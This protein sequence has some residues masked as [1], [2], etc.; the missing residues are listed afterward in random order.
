MLNGTSLFDFRA[1]RAFVKMDKDSSG[2]IDKKELT[3][4]MKESLQG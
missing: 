1:K 4:F 3:L 2:Y